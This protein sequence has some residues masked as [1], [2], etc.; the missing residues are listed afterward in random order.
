MSKAALVGRVARTAVAALGLSAAGIGFIQH[1]E[2]TVNRAYLDSIGKPTI[3][4]GHTGPEVRLGLVYTDAECAELLRT[5]VNSASAAIKRAIKVPLYQ[6]EF[7]AL[8]SFC[9]NVG[10]YNCTTSTMFTLINQ[11]RYEDAGKQFIR[12]KYAKKR[13]CSVRANN[14]YGVYLRR[15][16]EANL[17][18]GQY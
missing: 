11:G 7:D 10:N 14:C 13:D 1:E 9:F 17:W 15:I 8:V 16:N 4:T 18:R 12:W 2:G 5:D 6:Y 3:C